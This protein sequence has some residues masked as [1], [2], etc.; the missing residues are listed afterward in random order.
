MNEFPATLGL[1]LCGGLSRRFGRDKALVRP[2]DG[3]PRT[4]LER[5]V[6]V[7]EPLVDEVVLIRSQPVPESIRH[8]R[9]ADPSPGRGPARALAAAFLALPVRE[10]WLVAP[11]DVPGLRTEHYRELLAAATAAP[12]RCYRDAEALQPLVGV[13]TPRAASAFAPI[14]EAPDD[15]SLWHVVESLGPFVLDRSA[16]RSR[17]FQNWNRP[18]DRDR[19]ESSP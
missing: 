19:R 16:D 6:A 4:L 12:V 11:C 13:Y 9:F 1:V 7:L 3:D 8:R 10:H 5:A 15:P 2:D 17:P 18:V 14:L